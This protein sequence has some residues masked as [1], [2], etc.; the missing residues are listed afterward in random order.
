MFPGLSFKWLHEIVGALSAI[1]LG[2]AAVDIRPH[3]Q[4]QSNWYI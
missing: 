4:I 3:D 2:M 1:G